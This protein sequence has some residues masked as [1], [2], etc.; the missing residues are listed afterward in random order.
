ML[1]SKFIDVVALREKLVTFTI[2]IVAAYN[3][4]PE[5]EKVLAKPPD[6]WLQSWIARGGS[7]YVRWRM[8]GLLPGRRP[9]SQQWSDHVGLEVLGERFGFK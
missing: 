6:W 9:A 2:D 8:H 1:F 5:Q 3:S 4:L 7:P